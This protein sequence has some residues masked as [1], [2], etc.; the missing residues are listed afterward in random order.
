MN[1]KNLT[2]VPFDEIVDCFLL[3][4]ENYY[5]TVP[6]DKKYYRERWKAAKVNYDYSYG[7]FD[8]N[9]LVGFIIHAIDHRAGALTAYN[10][11]TGVL[12][13]YR[14]RRIVKSIYE[15]ALKALQKHG[16]EKS[17]LEVITKNIRAIR[18][19]ESIGFKISKTYSC[20]AGKIKNK[21]VDRFDFNEIPM[22]DVKWQNL[23]NQQFYSWDFQKE[24]ILER[25]YTF[26]QVFYRDKP[27]SFFIIDPKTQILAQFDLL[28]SE[29]L[30]W[31]RLFAAIREVS[32]TIKVINVDHKLHNK[33]KA[34]TSIGLKRSID[35][36]EME[37]TLNA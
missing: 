27:E 5:V 10:T 25:D 26:Y 37:L 8:K 23:P 15:Y 13:G 32:D 24:T 22:G 2:H 20:F 4:F 31:E 28:N 9:K 7:M 18:S 6:T 12:P 21:S 33:I 34:L 36:Y 16:I 30:G 35:Q 14:G 11:G 29:N 3:S 19:Y 17:T 1:I